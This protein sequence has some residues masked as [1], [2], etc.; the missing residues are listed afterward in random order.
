MEYNPDNTNTDVILQHVADAGHDN[1]KYTAK[2]SI[3]NKLPACCHYNRDAKPNS[4]HTVSKASY[5]VKGNCDM[6]KA[7][8]EKAS[9]DAGALSAEWK[10]DEQKLYLE[11]DPAKPLLKKF[12]RK[13]QMPGMIMKSLKQTIKHTQVCLHAAISTV[14]LHLEKQIQRCIQIKQIP[15]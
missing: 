1:E 10:A 11:L 5:Y 14:L 13:L 2:D 15:K 8:I 7:R 9:K 6:C 3:Y 12:C 4:E